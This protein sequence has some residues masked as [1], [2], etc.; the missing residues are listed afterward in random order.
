MS[1]REAYISGLRKL[2]DLLEQHDEVPVPY[3]G[4]SASPMTFHFLRSSVDNRAAMAAAVRAFPGRLDKDA[5]SN[6]FD[7]SGQ[8]DGL[9]VTFTAFRNEVCERVVVGTE[10][11]TRVIK[12]AEA[13]A[14]VPEVQVTEE[15][16]IVEWRCGS[17]LADAA[18][19]AVVA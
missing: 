4:S 11:V 12:D 6:Y 16:E 5:R 8:L 1:D 13:L 15:V 14:K 7:L 17:L 3:Q 10:T 9:H 2:A 19:E 18:P